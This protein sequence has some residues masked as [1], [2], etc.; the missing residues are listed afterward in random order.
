MDF[1]GLHV[2]KPHTLTLR[3]APGPG[4][5]QGESSA[6]GRTLSFRLGY[7]FKAQGLQGPPERV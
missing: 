1:P 2:R 6:R 7:G 3:R 5:E 4:M